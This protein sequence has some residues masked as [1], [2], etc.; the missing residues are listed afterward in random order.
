MKKVIKVSDKDAIKLTWG[1]MKSTNWQLPTILEGTS[2]VYAEFTEAH[3]WSRTKERE[4]IYMILEGD[5]HFDINGDTYPVSK[6]DVIVIPKKSRY[7]YTPT[8]SLLK[9]ILV[10]ELWGKK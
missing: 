7:N 10:M 8:S 9:I 1:K 3:G 5:A 2:L 6:G 4:R